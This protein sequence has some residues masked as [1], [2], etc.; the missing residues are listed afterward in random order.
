MLARALMLGVF[1]PAMTA[2]AVLLAGAMIGRARGRAAPA[3][4]T[5]VALLGGFLAGFGAL[6]GIPSAPPAETW[7]W[8]FWVAMTAAGIGALTLV[9]AA[10]K[11]LRAIAA[12]LSVMVA[13]WFLVP[14]WD[15]LAAARPWWMG[16]LLVAAALDWLVLHARGAKIEARAMCAIA[17]AFATGGAIVLGLSG[18]AKLAQLAGTLATASVTAFV[19]EA[20]RRHTVDARGFGSAIGAVLC[21]IMFT[22]QF[23]NWSDTPIEAF[24]VVALSPLVLTLAYMRAVDRLA[25]ARRVVVRLVIVLV[26]VGVAVGLAAKARL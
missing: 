7:Q 6:F 25:A 19:L 26:P 22:G 12:L 3:C 10:P 5:P 1:V 11:W 16:G 13:A 20:C 18:N 24:L 15:S 17:L 2:G 21:G 4:L 9:D 14:R 23:H 8:L